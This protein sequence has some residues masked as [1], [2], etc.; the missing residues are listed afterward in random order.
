MSMGA[1]VGRLG[2]LR[3]S[4]LDSFIREACLGEVD[5]YICR[6]YLIDH[7][8]HIEIA[9]ELESRYGIRYD[10]CTVTRHWLRCKK[11]IESMIPSG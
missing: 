6:R 2:A 8:P 10:R 4:Q 11:K 7:I 5:E 1:H 3:R 9:G